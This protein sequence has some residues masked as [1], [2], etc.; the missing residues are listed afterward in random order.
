MSEKTVILLNE[1]C[2]SMSAHLLIKQALNDKR[3]SKFSD[4]GMN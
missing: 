4:D 2:V 1:L 3:T